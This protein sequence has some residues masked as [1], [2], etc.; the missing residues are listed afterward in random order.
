MNGARD[1]LYVFVGLAE[2][3]DKHGR[4]TFMRID[5]DPPTNEHHADERFQ[6]IAHL[7][8]QGQ[9]KKALIKS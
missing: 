9:E 1:P 8:V 3:Q 5:G 4:T 6:R 2:L 7:F